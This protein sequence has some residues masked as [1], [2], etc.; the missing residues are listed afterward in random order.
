MALVVTLTTVRLDPS[1]GQIQANVEKVNMIA[2][3]R[4]QKHLDSLEN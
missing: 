1:V 2:G 3:E 4:I